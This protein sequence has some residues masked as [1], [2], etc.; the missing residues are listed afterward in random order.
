[1]YIPVESLNDRSLLALTELHM[2]DA[3]SRRL[4]VL[5][6][7]QKAGTLTASERNELQVLT[8]IYEGGLLRKSQALA[9]AVKRGLLPP[10]R[11]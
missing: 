3:Q 1:M 11:D 4:G 9:E 7:Y 6:A 8:I 10:L 5:L 2:V